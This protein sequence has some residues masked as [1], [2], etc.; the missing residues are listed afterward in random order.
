VLRAPRAL[1]V[2]GRALASATLSQFGRV[3]LWAVVAISITGVAR[4]TGELSSP[5]QLLNTGYGRSLLLKTSLLA[6]ALVLARGN[7]RMVGA[8]AGGLPPTLRKLRSVGRAV[9]AELVIA[10]CIVVVAAVLVAQ[11]PRRA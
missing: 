9:Q 8:L 4:A 6:P 2:A 11:I 5:A 7:R 3:A 10:M 1:P